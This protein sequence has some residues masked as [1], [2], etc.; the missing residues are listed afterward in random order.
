MT[1]SP[2]NRNPSTFQFGFPPSDRFEHPHQAYYAFSMVGMAGFNSYDLLVGLPMGGQATFD[3]RRFPMRSWVTLQ[4][5][6]GEPIPLAIHIDGG[7]VTGQWTEPKPLGNT[8]PNVPMSTSSQPGAGRALIDS[9]AAF[10]VK[11]LVFYVH[12]HARQAFF[13]NRP[14]LRVHSGVSVPPGAWP[15]NRELAERMGNPKLVG[16]WVLQSFVLGSW[17]T[18]KDTALAIMVEDTGLL[19]ARWS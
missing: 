4:D 13:V 3:L 2:E 8:I 18:L 1:M 9:S 5:E 14:Q 17:T 15:M 16:I 10:Q 6:R 11:D 19:H 12:P 7:V